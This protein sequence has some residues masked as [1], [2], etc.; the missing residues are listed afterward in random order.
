MLESKRSTSDLV[1]P[2]IIS[3]LERESRRQKIATG[4][5]KGG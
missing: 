3:D 5:E 4:E 1:E 2:D